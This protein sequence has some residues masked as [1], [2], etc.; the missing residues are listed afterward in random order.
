MNLPHQKNRR[1][2]ELTAASVAM[3]EKSRTEV[4][5]VE[6]N[7]TDAMKRYGELVRDIM[8]HTMKKFDDQYM[9]VQ[10]A[11]FKGSVIAYTDYQPENISRTFAD[12]IDK[13]APMHVAP[14]NDGT[15]TSYFTGFFG[16][17]LI[18]VLGMGIYGYSKQIMPSQ[19]AE[20]E[21]ITQLLGLIGTEAQPMLGGL[22]GPQMAAADLGTAVIGLSAGLLTLIF[23]FM[24][25][26]KKA[27]SNLN[28]AEQVRAEAE[29][30]CKEYDALQ[31]KEH[32]FADYVHTLSDT[33]ETLQIF[34]DEYVA[35]MRRIVHVEGND[36][37]AYN[38]V[39][40]EEVHHTVDMYRQLRGLMKSR[41]VS[42]DAAV[43]EEAKEELER[44]KAL[45]E[46]M[47]RVVKFEQP[48]ESAYM[49]VAEKVAE[50]K[51][52]IEEAR[53]LRGGT[54]ATVTG[55]VA[56]EAFDTIEAETEPE[57]P[58]M[59]EAVV[60]EEL[61][62]EQDIVEGE[63]TGVGETVEAVETAEADEPDALTAETPEAV[64]APGDEPTIETPDLPE[65]P[66]AEPEAVEFEAF[67]E[68][69]DVQAAIEPVDMPETE[70]EAALT[71]EET[72]TEVPEA[73]L[74]TEP[75]AQTPI[76]TLDL[77]EP[78][79]P[80]EAEEFGATEPFAMDETAIEKELSEVNETLPHDDAVESPE[81]TFEAPES[82]E[83]SDMPETPKNSEPTDPAK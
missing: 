47:E 20:T 37:N 82:S 41:I 23:G 70:I 55:V 35:R 69:P 30:K 34:L 45:A 52:R 43:L 53:M 54:A 4:S 31:T 28:R 79:E 16:G 78:M 72:F 71:D 76:D 40:K 12:K 13:I 68:E 33:A 58:A 51:R 42:A 75:E 24:A 66:E 48:G 21:T 32:N 38:P 83:S 7:L 25:H 81:A 56:A 65:M 80:V 15:F 29:A 17:T 60:E 64:E 39:S 11:H 36:Y 5:E 2:K 3:L 61:V 49:A 19:L 63:V 1:A 9:E 46:K 50:Q 27:T 6:S 59:E 26:N 67:D 8:G 77:A 44:T 73:A 74:E 10:K 22:F 62:A 18:T 14:V 57:A